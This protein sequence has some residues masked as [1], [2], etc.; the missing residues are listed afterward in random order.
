MSSSR[1]EILR[2]QRAFRAVLNAMARPGIVTG[3]PLPP[4]ETVR[5]PGVSASLATLID[6]FVD[7]AT[8]FS[9][10]PGFD[11]FDTERALSTAIAAET[12]ARIE[13][14][15]AAA[16]IVVP[17]AMCGERIEEAVAAACGGSF[18]SPEAGATVLVECGV[19]ATGGEDSPAVQWVSIE[20]PGVKDSHVFGT[21]CVDWIWARNRRSDEFPCGIDIILT[22]GCGR[23]AAVPRTS[24]VS[25]LAGRG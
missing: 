19:V 24:F 10:V 9:L 6:M 4:T 17:R 23:V 21:D 12:H 14:A 1:S 15:D 18:E 20:G 11:G 5:Y 16:F 2:M 25:L 3:M 22:D 8:T 7:Q 13:S